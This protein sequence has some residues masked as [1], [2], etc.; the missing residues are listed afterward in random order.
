[1]A[2]VTRRSVALG[3]AAGGGA[4]LIGCQGRS[5]AATP[6]RP[7]ADLYDCD[8]CEAVAERSPATLGWRLQLADAAEP[9][10]RMVLHGRVTLPDGRTPAPGVVIYAHQTNAAGL[11]ANGTP[12]TSWSRRHGALRGWVK[13]DAAGR[14]RFDTIKPAPYPDRSMPAHVH[15]FVAE[16]GRPPYYIDDAVFAGEFRVDARYRAAQELRGGS[17]IVTLARERDSLIARRD[18]V[19]ERH[20][21]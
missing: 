4:L 15:L 2:E 1:M 6:R 18:I 13:T 19:L 11:Y 17:G 9:G 21:G 16:P 3:L 7:R 12:E 20:P 14:Y 5:I 10:E 8:G